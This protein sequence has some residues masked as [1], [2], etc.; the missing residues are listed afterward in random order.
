M[1]GAIAFADLIIGDNDLIYGTFTIKAD[2]DTPKDSAEEYHAFW[3]DPRSHEVRVLPLGGMRL[4]GIFADGQTLIGSLSGEA[5]LCD[6]GCQPHLLSALVSDT[7]R[8]WKLLEATDSNSH[9]DIVGYGLS[10]G[11]CHYF[12]LKCCSRRG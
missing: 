9:G 8:G 11:K 4:N 3:W 2:V 12:M 6:I 7:A 1:E 5:A 10:E